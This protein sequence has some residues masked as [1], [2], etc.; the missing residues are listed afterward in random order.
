MTT[1]LKSVNTDK[2][3]V[4]YYNKISGHDWKR[5]LEAEKK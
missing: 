1:F 3:T 5:I 4:S 2:G